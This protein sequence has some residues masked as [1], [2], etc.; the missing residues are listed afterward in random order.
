MYILRM[1]SCMLVCSLCMYLTHT[2]RSKDTL[3]SYNACLPA[4]KIVGYL[5][6]L[7]GDEL[8]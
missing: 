2:V 3:R 6:G 4:V 8:S 7:A 5:L 1:F